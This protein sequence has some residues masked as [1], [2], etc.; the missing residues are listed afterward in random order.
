[1]RSSPHDPAQSEEARRK[2]I[3]KAREMSL[4][5]RAW[6]RQ[7]G[8][9]ADPTIYEREILPKMQAMSVRR[10]VSI[11]GL[12]EYYLWKIRKGQGG[13]HARF[14]HLVASA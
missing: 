4:A 7:H 13:L 12:S 5:A 9:V 1:M 3:E 8:L 10:L 11:T 6:E 2:R 14:W